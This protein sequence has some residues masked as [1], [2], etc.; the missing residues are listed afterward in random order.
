MPMFLWL[1][2]FFQLDT[3]RVIWEKSTSFEK[4]ASI[5][6]AYRQV[7]VGIFLIHV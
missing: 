6:L 5:R 4:N 3:V 1:V 2:F 7:C